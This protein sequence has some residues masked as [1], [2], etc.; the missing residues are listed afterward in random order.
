MSEKLRL[1][2]ILTAAAFLCNGQNAGANWFFGV[3]AGFTFT[4]SVPTTTPNGALTNSLGGSAVSDAGG[5]LLFYT[6]GVTVYDRTHSVMPNGTLLYGVNATQPA[7]IIRRP[8]SPNLYY[9]FTVGGIGSPYGLYY[10]VVDMNLSSGNGS[11]TA[12]N[13]QVHPGCRD[14]LTA[15]RHCNGSDV[16][17]VSPNYNASPNFVACL[18]TSAGVVSVVTSPSSSVGAVQGIGEMKLSPNGSKLV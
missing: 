14:K 17:I 10:S 7:L 18:L 2:I 6:D 3:N 5:G 11:V 8:Q 4:A 15:G 9:I 1:T 13:I 16:W 12:K